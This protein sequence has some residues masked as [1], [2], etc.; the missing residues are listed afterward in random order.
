MQHRGLHSFKQTCFLSDVTIK[1]IILFSQFYLILVLILCDF[2]LISSGGA[3]NGGGLYGESGTLTG[4]K[5]PVGLYGTFCAV[6]NTVLFFFFL[7]YIV[8]LNI[9]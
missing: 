7:G 1:S 8:V 3:G 9:R 4:K 5:C 2:I 6:S